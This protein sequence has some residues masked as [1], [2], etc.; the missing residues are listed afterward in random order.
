MSSKFLVMPAGSFTGTYETISLVPDVLPS[1]LTH[2]FD[3][4]DTSSLTYDGSN[5]ISAW[6][7]QV[8]ANPLTAAGND[9]PLFVASYAG[10]PAVKLEATPALNYI[11]AS[12]ITHDIR[13]GYTV[14]AVFSSPTTANGVLWSAAVDSTNRPSILINANTLRVRHTTE[15]LLTSSFPTAAPVIVLLTYNSGAGTVSFYVNG[16]LVSGS[17]AAIS[18]PGDY[19]NIFSGKISTFGSSVLHMHRLLF[20]NANM[21]TGDI[22]KVNRILNNQFSAY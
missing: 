4:T 15:N 8:G 5:K 22:A 9:R 12:S 21:G 10:F 6:A 7:D 19:R 16:S 11:G 17:P 13:T 2:D 18:A 1:T 14:A 20:F 3:A